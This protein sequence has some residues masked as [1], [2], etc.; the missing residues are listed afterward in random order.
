MSVHVC[1]MCPLTYLK[2]HTSKLRN[3]LYVLTVAVAVSSDDNVIRYLL[4]VLWMTS[5][6]AHNRPGKRDA[7]TRMLKVSHQG[8]NGGW[9]SV[10]P[11]VYT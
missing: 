6:F 2:D 4:P 9:R 7:N 3:L 11:V 5:C 8:Q 1:L 10:M